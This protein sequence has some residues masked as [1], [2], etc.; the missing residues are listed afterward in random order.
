MTWR[1]CQRFDCP[2]RISNEDR[3]GRYCSTECEEKDAAEISETAE[4][5]ELAMLRRRA[6]DRHR[7][8]LR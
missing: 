8:L 3:G 7:G 2:R 1:H 6:H 4:A 5:N